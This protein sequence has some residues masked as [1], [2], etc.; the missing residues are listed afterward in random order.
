LFAVLD[1][2]GLSA[3]DAIASAVS[4]AT[5]LTE[6]ATASMTHDRTKSAPVGVAPRRP[7]RRRSA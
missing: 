7:T 5:T 6:A 2:R 1:L 4:T 3:D